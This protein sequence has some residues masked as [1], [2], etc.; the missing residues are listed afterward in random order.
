MK[1]HQLTS[2]DGCKLY[3]CIFSPD[4]KLRGQVLVVHGMGEHCARHTWLMN[5]LA[6][7]GLECHSLDLR[8][9]GRSDGKRG[10]VNSW[11]DYCLD[12]DAIAATLDPGFSVL[13]H[14][15]GGLVALDW[16]RQ[17]RGANALVLSSP[18]LGVAVE[19]PAWKILAGRLLSRILPSL[20][21]NNELPPEDICSRAEVVE[22]YLAD[23]MVFGTITPR[24]FTEMSAAIERVHLAASS[25]D[26]PLYLNLGAE[27][28]I[29]SLPDARKFYDNWNGPKRLQEW[30]DCFHETF[31]EA[32]REQIVAPISDWLISPG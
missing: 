26:I 12:L 15:M 2:A 19:A 11:N 20:S 4:S 22:A 21:M 8:G 14:S 3:A 31:N 28:K 9:H 32:Q 30:E 13:G 1:E 6:E 25:Y 5:T 17:N 27:D 7:A 29:V 16:L 23:P 24:W 18:L 10:H